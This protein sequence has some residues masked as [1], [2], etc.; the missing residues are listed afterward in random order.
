[1]LSGNLAKRVIYLDYPSLLG[2]VSKDLQGMPFHPYILPISEFDSV[3][4]RVQLLPN[5]SKKDIYEYGHRYPLVSFP[6]N[7]S[8]RKCHLQS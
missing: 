1:M 3:K 6:I 5:V 2:V 8:G 7:V 4:H